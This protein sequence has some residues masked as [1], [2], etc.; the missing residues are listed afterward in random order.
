MAKSIIYQKVLLRLKAS[1]ERTFMISQWSAYTTGCLL[2]YEY[3]KNCFRLIV[4]G[5]S[6]QKKLYEDPKPIKQIEFVEQWE[7]Y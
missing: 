1:L 7:K 6:R 4:V 5:F 3:N 2:D